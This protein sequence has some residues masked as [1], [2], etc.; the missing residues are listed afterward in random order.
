MLVHARE[1][2]V[3]ITWPTSSVKV[4]DVPPFFISAFEMLWLIVRQID[5]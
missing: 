2:L 5:S 1:L 4:E 3:Q